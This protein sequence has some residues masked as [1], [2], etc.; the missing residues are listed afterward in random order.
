M[1]NGSQKEENAEYKDSMN[2]SHEEIKKQIMK[3]QSKLSLRECSHIQERVCVW[4]YQEK[5]GISLEF[6]IFSQKFLNDEDL[7]SQPETCS[8]LIKVSRNQRQK[9]FMKLHKYNVFF[10]F[11]FLQETLG[12]SFCKQ[13]A[14]ENLWFW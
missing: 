8:I 5:N 9:I 10:L 6:N 2:K 13:E 4:Y 1:A 11:L 14:L 3:Q 12:Q 7:T